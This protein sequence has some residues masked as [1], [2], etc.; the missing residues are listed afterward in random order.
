MKTEN[1]GKERGKEKGKEKKK[2][3]RKKKM[4]LEYPVVSESTEAL[5][6]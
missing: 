2:R 6:D 5:K 4:N 3:K 1:E